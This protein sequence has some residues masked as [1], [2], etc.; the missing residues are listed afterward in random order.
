M[1]E[2]W[3]SFSCLISY[4]VH[5]FLQTTTCTATMMISAKPP[6]PK[7][8]VPWSGRNDDTQTQTR[9]TTATEKRTMKHDVI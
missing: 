6:K 5:T 1:K 2:K 4:I 8:D 9:K 3:F 7:K